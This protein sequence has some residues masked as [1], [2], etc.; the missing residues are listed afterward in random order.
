M[1]ENA[2]QMTSKSQTYLILKNTAPSLGFI[3]LVLVLLMGVTPRQSFIYPSLFSFLWTGLKVGG[4]Q[5]G[6]WL[7][8][9]ACGLLALTA[10]L[11]QFNLMRF[12]KLRRTDKVLQWLTSCLGILADLLMFYCL[13]AGLVLLSSIYFLLILIL[14]LASLVLSVL[15]LFV[16]MDSASS[17]LANSETTSD[18][19]VARNASQENQQLA[20]KTEGEEENSPF[21]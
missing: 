3:V 11:G 17:G 19:Q 16:G 9:I 5:S 1:T 15:N 14:L 13:I 18:N 2:N 4:L 20:G 6:E 7:I 8:L 12:L 21:F 10:I